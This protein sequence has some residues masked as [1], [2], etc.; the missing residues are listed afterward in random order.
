VIGQRVGLLTAGLLAALAMAGPAA[1][2]KVVRGKTAA[3]VFAEPGLA[4]LARG[5]CEGDLGAVDR[6]LKAGAD[7]NGKGEWGL[8]PL[9]WAEMCG[10]V[11]GMEALL[12][13]GA[14]PNYRLAGPGGGAAVGFASQI[15][16]PAVLKLVLKY[17]GK[18]NTTIEGSPH[19]ALE[20]AFTVGWAGKGWDNYY[21]LLDAGADIN[22]VYEGQTIALSAAALDRYDKV[23]ELLD[24]GY[25]T[26]LIGLAR[27]VTVSEGVIQNGA[28]LGAFL[29][30]QN[31][32]TS[33]EGKVMS[34]DVQ[35]PYLAKVKAALIA[36]GL[37]FPVPPLIQLPDYHRP[38]D[39]CPL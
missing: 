21:A 29:A 5:A 22:C 38:A 39:S 2:E 12:R 19:T 33:S 14:D 36:K 16:N 28:R 30:Q 18:P 13:A 1:A 4:A 6:A 20:M 27:S 23:V 26:D 31:A 37:S 32:V 34:A 25:H 8:T 11:P 15:T 10:G 24:R 7:A 35:A 17:G 3:Q 9:L